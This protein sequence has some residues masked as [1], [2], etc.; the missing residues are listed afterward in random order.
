MIWWLARCGKGVGYLSLDGSIACRNSPSLVRIQV[1]T[2]LYAW[3]ISRSV[4]WCSESLQ[5]A[6]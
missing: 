4:K 2:A 5:G 1:L 3:A 6:C